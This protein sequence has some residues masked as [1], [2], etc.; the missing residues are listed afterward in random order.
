M[1][2]QLRARHLKRGALRLQLRARHLSRGALRLQLRA[3]HLKR[4][5]LRLQLRALH[6]KRSAWCFQRGAFR[7]KRSAWCFQRGAF[8]IKRSP[9][10]L[11][12][13]FQRCKCFCLLRGTRTGLQ[14]LQT[15]AG[16]RQLL[17]QR[18]R[19]VD[20]RKIL[21]HFVCQRVGQQ[22]S[23]GCAAVA[24]RHGE[25]H[26]V[27]RS[28]LHLCPK[29]S[30]G[31]RLHRALQVGE[32]SALHQL[33]QHAVRDGSRQHLLRRKTFIRHCNRCNCRVCFLAGHSQR[34]GHNG[35][36]KHHHRRHAPV[37]EDYK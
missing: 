32:L 26:I 8:R 19:K 37:A 18:W 7:I 15:G 35:R 29:I 21:H 6:L 13:H 33:A 12:P 23:P 36:H 34:G 20:A 10:L 30:S 31:Q 22:G 3:L 5:A 1:R 17:A 25:D 27:C 2:L 28:N 24:H 11:K 4:G 14:Q 16:I 9:L